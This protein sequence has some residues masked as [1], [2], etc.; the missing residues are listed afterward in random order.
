MS[1]RY[2]KIEVAEWRCEIRFDCPHC[3]VSG[4]EPSEYL[5]EDQVGLNG[6]E[7]TCTECEGKVKLEAR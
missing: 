5:Y 1:D 4:I 6:L 2:D 3:E 7:L